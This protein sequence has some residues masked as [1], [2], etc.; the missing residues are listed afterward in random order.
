MLTIHNYLK[1][2]TVLSGN[3]IVIL[4]HGCC[5]L[6]INCSTNVFYSKI[7][8]MWSLGEVSDP[9]L[10]SWSCTLLLQLQLTD[11]L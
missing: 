11:Q 10:T 3:H 4:Y 9:G 8:P 2:C 1:T 5:N 7:I 6:N